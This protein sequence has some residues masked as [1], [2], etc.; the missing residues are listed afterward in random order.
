MIRK[1]ISSMLVLA[2]V[3]ASAAAFLPG[4]VL[5][6][7][8]LNAAFSTTVSASALASPSAG[9]GA[10]LVGYQRTDTG[11]VAR[12]VAD[13]LGDV[14]SAKDYGV[15][16]D[17]T[18]DD[19]ATINAA[20]AANAGKRVQLPAGRCLYQGGGILQAGE[21]LV[22]AGRNSTFIVA[23]R[24]ANTLITAFGYGSGIERVAFYS[25]VT[26]TGGSYVVLAGS[27][28]YIDD[29]YMTGDYNGI[30]MTGN[31]AR[32]RHGRFQDGAAGAIRIR[33]E[34]GD[35]SQ[36]IDDV[37]MGAQSPEVSYAGIRVRN[38]SA[39]IISNTSVIQQNIGL[40]VDPY[41]ST[42]GSATDAGG[43]YSLWVHHSFFDTNHTNGIRIVPSGS[44]P[45][46]RSRF[47]SVWASSSGADGVYINNTGTGLLQGLHFVSPHLLFNTGNGFVTSGSMS[48][49]SILGG[50]I[51]QNAQGVTAG[52]G[53]SGLRINGALIG[54]GAGGSGNTNAGISIAS[55]ADYLVISGNDLRG[56]GTAISNAGGSNQ[57]IDNNLGASS[58][59]VGITGGAINATPIGAATPS[60]GA[61]TTLA[62]SGQ[63]SSTVATGT[64]PFAVSSTTPVAN[65]SIGGNAATVT[66]L[67]V[68]SGKT[69]T[70][71]NSLT[72]AGTDG[73]TLNVGGGGT[74]GSAAYTAS[75][76]YLAAGGT[77]ANASQ[78]LGSTWAAPAAIGS[79]TPAAGYFTT[80]NYSQNFGIGSATSSAGIT[81]ASNATGATTMFGVRDVQAIQSGVTST[82]VSYSSVPSTAATAF[83]LSSLQHFRADSA[84]IG[85]GSAITTQT[86][87]LASGLTGATNNYGFQSNIA[88]ASGAWEF[89]ALGGANNAFA[90]NTRF[91]GTT[92]PA[93]TV[94]VTGSVAATSS[95]L[96]SSP[97]A[98]VGYKTGA[99]GSATQA[100][101]KTT[102][103]TLNTVTGQIT[104]NSA[105][106]ATATT[107][108]FT[109]TNSSI[110]AYDSISKSIAS[111]ATAGAYSLDVDA[112]AAGSARFCLY[113][114]SGG[115]L[116]E[117]PVI[118]F[119]VIKGSV[120]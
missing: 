95:I 99:G 60:S 78:L 29:F 47:D 64:A 58:T 56:N 57:F 102:G 41:T 14:I 40:L 67:S 117:S 59:I 49:V 77:A 51:G 23:T 38:S 4:Q 86:G 118:N 9:Q 111:G 70:S 74:L 13:K 72:L 3:S 100:T 97:T 107:A 66:G 31:V 69:L 98:G 106:L 43:V 83:T 32:V 110:G 44:A 52:S 48:D 103:V 19:T 76:A 18:T 27:E 65:L 53:L 73:S 34:G 6:A 12:T 25:N 62:A 24:P 119:A 101:S 7:S 42:Q 113:N 39:L 33:A 109:M 35:N 50:E 45:V 20:L 16:C 104:M 63:I 82:Y 112:V 114:H 8:E 30:L 88:A 10:G 85:S 46:V 71:T 116:S 91:G 80:G 36:L 37:L 120:N 89:A 17:N 15:K 79:T 96:S 81:L 93:A 61:F 108:C 84:I 1:L 94:D 54:Q 2:S 90:G 5:T 55:G 26:Q 75:S 115:S 87:F 21:V 68:S 92:A 22:G 28:S 11:A 105:A